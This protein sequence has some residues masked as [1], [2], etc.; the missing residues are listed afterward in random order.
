MS[1]RNKISVITCTRNSA[2]T[3][4][5]CIESVRSQ[6]HE[7]IEHIVIDCLSADGT[8][9]IVRRY[10]EIKLIS[11]KD[12]GIYDGFNKG[13][14]NATGSIVHFLNSDDR[15]A[16]NKVLEKVDKLFFTRKLSVLFCSTRLTSEINFMANR[17]FP[18]IKLN[19]KNL[20]NYLMPPHPGTFIE[21]SVLEG[22][23]GFNISFNFAG[24]FELL[25]RLNKT[26]NTIVGYA[27]FCAVEMLAGG[28]T[29]SFLKN[30]LKISREL[31]KALKNN[32]YKNSWVKLYLRFFRK[33]ILSYT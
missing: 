4:I 8:L 3:I 25:A 23:G 26:K 18:P 10:P 31:I 28:A 6:S 27:D 22:L 24:D 15:Y 12:C 14:A 9:E 7:R 13:I 32:N 1:S 2:S 20:E 5:S 19:K 33:F 29:S 30:R 21:R 17:N 11:E 16:S